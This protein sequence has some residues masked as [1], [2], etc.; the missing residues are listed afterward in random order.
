MKILGIS[1]FYHDS[2]I[3]II[4]LYEFMKPKSIQ[5]IKI[6]FFDLCH[7]KKSSYAKIGKFVSDCLNNNSNNNELSDLQKA[8]FKNQINSSTYPLW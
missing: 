6:D 5:E 1:C 4:D 3:S 7:F 2:S 8:E